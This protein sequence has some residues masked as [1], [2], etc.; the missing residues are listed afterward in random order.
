MCVCKRGLRT[1]AL[2]ALAATVAVTVVIVRER[3]THVA[4]EL[5]DQAEPRLIAVGATHTGV[6]DQRRRKPVARGWVQLR[7][8]AWSGAR[9]RVRTESVRW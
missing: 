2:C 3:H 1:G 6:L 5:G 8:P 4:E 9:A 7:R